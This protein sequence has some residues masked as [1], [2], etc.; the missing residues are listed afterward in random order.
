[1]GRIVG[2]IG[3]GM[4]YQGRTFGFATC[5]VSRVV[6]LRGSMFRIAGMRCCG[7]ED[8]EW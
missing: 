6:F 2:V 1:M 5:V 8:K 7:L 3:G 4:H